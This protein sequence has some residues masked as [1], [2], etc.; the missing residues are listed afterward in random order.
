MQT[1]AMMVWVYG[2][3]MAVGGVIGYLKVGSKA[4]L[5][6]GVGFGLALA[7]SGYGVWRGSRESLIAS[8]VIAAL[9]IVIFAMRVL[10]TRR[11]MPAGLLALLS[12]AAL[13]VFLAALIK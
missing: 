3:L 8:A 1:M 5:I 12:L 13:I 2:G 10:K 6:S 11:F 4:S 7:A 9:V